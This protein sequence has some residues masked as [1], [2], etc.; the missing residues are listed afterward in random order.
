MSVSTLTSKGQ[1]T[2]PK[3][4]RDGLHLK[5]GD[6]VK[7]FLDPDGRVVMLPILAVSRL[8]GMLKSKRRRPLTL[9]EMDKAVAEG[10]ARAR[11]RTRR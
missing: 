7:F 4:I 5:P 6:R 11:R 2:V 1:M 10:A 8:R 3:E 9:K